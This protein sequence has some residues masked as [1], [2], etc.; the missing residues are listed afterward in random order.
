MISILLAIRNE[1]KNLYNFLNFLK[2]QSN[3]N[4]EVIII[5]YSDNCKSLIFLK[6]YKG[7]RNLKIF[8]LKNSLN[9]Q[10]KRGAQVNQAY[11]RSKGEI[12]FFPDADMYCSIH[13]LNEIKKKMN[14]TKSMYIQEKIVAKGLYKKFRNFERFFYNKTVI[15][16][17]RVLKREVF[18]GIGGFDTNIDFGADDWD[19]SKKV[20]HKNIKSILSKNFVYH[21]EI[22]LNF[23]KVLKKKINYSNNFD[24]YI[25]KWGKEDSDIKKQFGI[26]YRFFGIFFENKKKFIF[27]IK[28]LNLYFIFLLNKFLVGLFFIFRNDK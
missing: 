17:P 11:L 10:N 6:S 23:I 12:I 21:N 20:K 14:F 2:K 28:N 4:F 15:D 27:L 5:D 24:R 9:I 25:K 22:N 13:L 1:T 8:K 19:I 16:A 26:W 3:Q 18:I 7:I